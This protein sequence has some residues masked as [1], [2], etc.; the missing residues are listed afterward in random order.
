MGRR[1]G[2][3]SRTPVFLQ[4]P[5]QLRSAIL[6]MLA[7]MTAEQAGCWVAHNHEVTLYVGSGEAQLHVNTTI[8]AYSGSPHEVTHI[9]LLER[10]T[11][12]DVRVYILDHTDQGWR[13]RQGYLALTAEEIEAYAK[14]TTW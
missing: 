7:L 9:K 2:R 4:D 3:R 6:Q 1:L 8:W 13:P 11:T 14:T 10:T 12:D 5:E